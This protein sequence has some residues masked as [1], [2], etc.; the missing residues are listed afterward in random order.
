MMALSNTEQE[1]A[2]INAWN[3]LDGLI[4]MYPDGYIL[5][6]YYKQVTVGQ[7]QAWMQEAAY[8]SNRL[9]L[10][11]EYYKGKKSIFIYKVLA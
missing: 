8:D 5:V 11:S 1:E 4:K 7:A 6:P 10:R 3:D 2:W 9:I